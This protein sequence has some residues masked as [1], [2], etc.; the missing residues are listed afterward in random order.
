MSRKL[1]LILA[2][3]VAPVTTPAFA[4]NP[5]NA[6]CRR[7]AVHFCRGIS[8]D[9][10]VRDCLVAHKHQISHGCRAVLESHGY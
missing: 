3:S 8:E 4:D 10:R 7:D 9:Y 1:M 6:A 2:L 5:E